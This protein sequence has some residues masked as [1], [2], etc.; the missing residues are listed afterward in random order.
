V[1]LFAAPRSASALPPSAAGWWWKAQTGKAAV[2][3]PPTVP[4]GGLMVGGDPSG[5]N[6][7]AALRFEL[8]A[9]EAP[10]ILTLTVADNG[11]VNGA[12]AALAACPAG[13]A[14]SSAYAGAWPTRP[15]AAC[16][17]AAPGVRST[18]GKTWTFNVAGLVTAG[19]LDLVLTPGEGSSFNLVFNPP[20]TATLQTTAKPVAPAFTSPTIDSS[21]DSSIDASVADD[22]SSAVLDFGAVPVDASAF[23]AAPTDEIALQTPGRGALAARPVAA[24]PGNQREISGVAFV[25]LLGAAL[26]AYLLTKAETPVVRSLGPMTTSATTVRRLSP[27]GG[28]A[29]PQVGGL[30]R[31]TRTRQGPPPKL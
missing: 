21:A 1:V 27:R 12:S 10:T 31:F 14:W 29:E 13:S 25:L 16:A 19:R 22:G 30:G 3:S 8:A 18:D 9:D 11:D 5:A 2:P 17:R 24:I 7:L 26:A 6:A 20:T 4:G 28:P 23:V 15:N